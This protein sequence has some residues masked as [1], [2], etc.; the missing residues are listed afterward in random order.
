[1]LFLERALL[2]RQ[3]LVFWKCFFVVRKE[4]CYFLKG[5]YFLERALLVQRKVLLESSKRHI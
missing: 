2:S 3:D 5:P 4:F 1:M